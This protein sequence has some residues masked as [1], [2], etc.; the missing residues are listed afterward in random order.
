MTTA[1]R[2]GQLQFLFDQQVKVSKYDEWSFY[3][4]QFQNGCALDNKAV[5]ILCYSGDR[6]WLIEV[7]DYRKFSRTRAV[8]LAQEIA[9][10]VRDS[11][12]GLVAAQSNAN[13]ADEQRFARRFLRA[14]Q[15]Y[16]VCHLEQPFH[17]TR[18]RPQAIEPD[19]LKDQLRRLLR[20]VDPH[21]AVMDRTHR[22]VSVPWQVQQV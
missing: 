12:A 13:T 18:L 17:V 8:D 3:R 20:A 22:M 2:E 7:K 15:I 9:T 6:A 5:D 10:K 4:R 19:K 14:R 16:V 21:P 11:L 1:I